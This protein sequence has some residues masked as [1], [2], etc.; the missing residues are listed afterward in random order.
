MI[1]WLG[2]RMRPGRADRQWPDFLV[3]KQWEQPNLPDGT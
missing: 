3:L 2:N 1:L